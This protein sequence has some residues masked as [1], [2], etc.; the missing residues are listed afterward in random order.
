MSGTSLDGIDAAFLLSD[1]RSI[2]D[3]GPRFFTPYSAEVKTQLKECLGQ[4][5]RT[6]KTIY[7]EQLVTQAHINFAKDILIKSN[8]KPN[9][10]GFH[11]QTIF[12]APPNTLQLG[13][14]QA[15]AQATKINVIYDFRSNDCNNGGQGAPF[16]PIYH[17]ALCQNYEKPLAVLNIGGVANIT[18]ID[19]MD[20]LIGFD[21]GPGNALIDDYV[22]HH[23][24]F[25]YD[26][27]GAIAAQST[28]DYFL[29]NQWLE[30]PFFK[31]PYPKSL[32]RNTF[33][34]LTAGIRSKTSTDAVATLTYF[35]A[36]SIALALSKLPAPIKQLIICGGG[37]KNLTILK[38]L[39]EILHAPLIH[40]A[41]SAGW[42]GDFIEAEAFAFLAIRSFYGLPLSFP[43]TTGVKIPLTGG[44]VINVTG[45]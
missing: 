13:D 37:A 15:L 34:E 40:T 6:K 20:N 1:G 14:G 16:A 45:G 10:I 7:T 29:I 39:K 30:H 32:D 21:T 41:E 19:E 33:Q 11:G 23:Y 35:T 17:Q 31:K 12:H 3:K 18:Y 5:S 26:K 8:I 4:S 38:F 44:R 24:S 27:D 42:T 36:K 43:L 9:L 25:P 28:P 22:A 2:F